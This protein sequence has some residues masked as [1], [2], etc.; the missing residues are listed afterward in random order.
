RGNKFYFPGRPKAVCKKCE[1]GTYYDRVTPMSLKEPWISYRK[2]ILLD[3]KDSILQEITEVIEKR[4]VL[5]KS[6]EYRMCAYWCIATYF[7]RE[8]Q[9]FPY[10]QFSGVINSGKSRMLK[11]LKWFSYRAILHASCSPSVLV[12][13]IDEYH[14]TEL[15]DEIENKLNRK[16][17]SGSDMFN[18]LLEG[19]TPDSNY[20]RCKQ[21]QDRGMVQYEVYSPK[22]FAGRRVVDPALSSRCI[23]VSMRKDTPECE[24]IPKALSDEIQEIRSKLLYLK[25]AGETLPVV[26]PDLHGRTREIFIPIIAV[27]EYFGVDPSD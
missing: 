1:K 11:L 21:G 3:N 18:V 13:E 4:G 22:A 24:D 12:R 27:A 26:D 19:Y 7:Y 14:C 17:E 15:I 10:L 6:I 9:A 20:S 2:P 23:N 16:W 25:L 8:F 5:Q